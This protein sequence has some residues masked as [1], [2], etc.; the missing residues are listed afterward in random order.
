MTSAVQPKI[1][2][3]MPL[4]SGAIVVHRQIADHLDGYELRSY[5]PRMEYFPPLMMLLRDHEADIFHGTPDYSALLSSANQKLVITFHNFVLDDYMKAFS[6]RAQWLHYQTDL[7]LLTKIA[8]RRANVV[9]AVSEFIAA[10][11]RE[12]FDDS[13][14]VRVIPNGIDVGKYAPIDLPAAQTGS[15]KVLVCGNASMRKGTQW[16]NDVARALPPDVE[17]NCTLTENQLA[18]WGLTARNINALGKLAPED[19][20]SLYRAHDILFMPTAREGFGLAVAEAMASG[21]PVVASDNSTM[22]E[23]IEHGEG[24]YLCRTGA[25][26]EYA[27]AIRVLASDTGLRHRMGEFNRRRVQAR[28]RLDDMVDAYRRL[29][30]ELA[31]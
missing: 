5:S 6:S 14:P 8:V 7:K 30:A 27:D 15:V 19:M 28:Y 13:F 29:F 22:P 25:T 1:A 11:V 12:F 20:P 9:T 3:R 2:S 31:D 4:G 23:L 26:D 18:A 16:L 17:V 21:I 24:G 10:S